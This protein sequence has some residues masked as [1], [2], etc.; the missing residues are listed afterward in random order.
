MYTTN[1]PK[2]NGKMVCEG[3]SS[4]LVYYTSPQGHDHDDNCRSRS[5]FCTE[6]GEELL[7]S[8]R[9]KCPNPDCNWVGKESC[10]C[11]E[12]KKVDEWPEE[13]KENRKC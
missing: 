10:W 4:T 11:H 13:Y 3:T 9:N 8:K 7:I 1:C 2:C 5:Y 6:C 12:G